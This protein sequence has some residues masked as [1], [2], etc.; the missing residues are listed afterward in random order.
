MADEAGDAEIRVVA[1]LEE[2]QAALLQ[3]PAREFEVLVEA[4]Q[5]D[6]TQEGGPA[7]RSGTRT[8]FE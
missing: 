8:T 1:L 2:G 6:G 7:S 5:R 4:R 3:A